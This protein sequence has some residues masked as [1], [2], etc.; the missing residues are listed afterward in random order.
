MKA[1]LSRISLSEDALRALDPQRR[2]VFALIGH[3]FNELMLLQK[4]IHVS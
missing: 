4:L 3:I 1:Q 2:Y